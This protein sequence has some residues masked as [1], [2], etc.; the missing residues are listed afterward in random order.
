MWKG[1][2]EIMAVKS[3]S[4]DV[5]TM[6]KIR[7]LVASFDDKDWRKRHEARARV[8]KIGKPATPLLI[9]A[10]SHVDERVRWEA[11]KALVKIQA[12]E[13]ARA[14]AGALMDESFEVGWLAAEA[15][16]AL[17]KDALPAVL[18]G[19]ID[20]P[21][22]VSFKHGAHH[23]L[24]VFER[25]GILNE[26]SL[27]VMDELRDI[28]IAEAFSSTVRK[29]LNSLHATDGVKRDDLDT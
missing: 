20:N 10:L 2:D 9:D 14:L 26:E 29:A 6:E 17:G 25:K 1:G 23:V 21:G 27:K 7:G 24:H 5:A 13:A 15:L 11:A 4:D 18:Q 12:P 3:Y 28:E 22:S 8:E 16:I 19:L